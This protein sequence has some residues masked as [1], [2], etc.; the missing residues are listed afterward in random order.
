MD[1]AKTK[2]KMEILEKFVRTRNLT[3][4]YIVL[5]SEA[6]LQHNIEI[7]L[8]EIVNLKLQVKSLNALATIKDN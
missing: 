5:D 3:G 1:E 2:L 7:L 4:K 8:D 6:Q